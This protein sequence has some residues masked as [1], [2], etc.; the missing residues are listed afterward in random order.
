MLDFVDGLNIKLW[1]H[2]HHCCWELRGLVILLL[3]CFYCRSILVRSVGETCLC[4][5]CHRVVCSATR[6][7]RVF[8]M[9]LWFC[10][11]TTIHK[12]HE[13]IFWQFSSCLGTEIF[14]YLFCCWQRHKC[15]LI[16]EFLTRVQLNHNDGARTEQRLS[17]V[18]VTLM[19]GGQS[20]R[21][22]TVTSSP[23]QLGLT[24]TCSLEY[25]STSSSSCK[26]NVM[27]FICI[28][29]TCQLTWS[30]ARTLDQLHELNM[31]KR[32]WRKHRR[33]HD[34]YTILNLLIKDRHT[35]D[36]TELW[37]HSPEIHVLPK[38]KQTK[39]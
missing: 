13:G 25:M 15:N 31:E 24:S 4:T 26:C 37:Y 22:L 20:K 27:L 36:F 28:H 38:N 8:W 35:F 34:I 32:I 11:F 29:F 1:H 6:P 10:L 14:Y 2:H 3:T 21:N 33:H 16:Y 23:I 12:L 9:T 17:S 18:R 5:W 19:P 39:V 7:K 30:S